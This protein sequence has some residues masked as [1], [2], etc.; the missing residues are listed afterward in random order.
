MVY[1]NYLISQLIGL[2]PLL[3]KYLLVLEN[4]F[5]P[6]NPLYADNGDG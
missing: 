3:S 2:I 5:E 4:G 6:K 1:Y